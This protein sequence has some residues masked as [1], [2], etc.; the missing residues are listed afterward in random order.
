MVTAK[1]LRAPRPPRPFGHEAQAVEVHVGAAGDGHQ[2]SPLIGF[3]LAR[4]RVSLGTGHGQRTGRL[5]DA[6]G[7]LEDV[8]DGGADGVGVHDDDFVHQFFGD[9]EG[10]FA[11]QLDGRAVREQAHVGSVTRGRP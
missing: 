9:A 8:L 5:D 6:A 2:V 7:V 1:P 11:H 10:F 4:A 3:L